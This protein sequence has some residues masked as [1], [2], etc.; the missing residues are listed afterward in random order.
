MLYF[1]TEIDAALRQFA[2]DIPHGAL[3]LDAGAGESPHRELFRTQRY[4]AVDLAIGD[5]GWN[6]SNLDAIADLAALP[7]R[8]NVFAAALNVV[9][10]EHLRDPALALR[11]ISRVLKPGAS[12]LLVAPLE[13]EEHQQPHDFYRYTRHG[14]EYLLKN[15]GLHL[16]A[17]RPAGGFFRLLSRRLL[18][19]L[20]F[21][22]TG[23][24]WI[25]F[26]P[27]AAVFVPLSFVLPL[28]EPLDKTRHF[29][30]G[31]ICIARKS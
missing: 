20:Q 23:P 24:R 30:L 31:Y 5:P 18:N 27:A 10:L 26:A 12:L 19:G 8:S 17:I 9:T 14:L 28:F 13:W 22:M 7:F 11:E 1:E 4:V 3:V 6:Y 21:F 25:L 2:N 29:T 15:A 16:T